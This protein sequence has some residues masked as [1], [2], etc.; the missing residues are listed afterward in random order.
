[1][2]SLLRKLGIDAQAIDQPLDMSIPENKVLMAMYIVTAEVENERR[3]L[4]VKYGIYKAKQ[5]GRWMGHAPIGYINTVNESGR[6]IIT[7]HEPEATLIRQIF[8]RVEEQSSIRLLYRQSKEKGLKCS[9]NAFWNMIRNPV[10]CG[11]V[12]IPA[13]DGKLAYEVKGNHEPLISEELFRD[14]QSKIENK[15]EKT[16]YKPKS[17]CLA[18]YEGVPILPTLP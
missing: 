13:M 14:V 15:E 1:M 12:K 5:E 11:R 8:T 7:P 18:C 17:K 2:I 4:N 10:Y 9:L 3:S 6:K 16:Q